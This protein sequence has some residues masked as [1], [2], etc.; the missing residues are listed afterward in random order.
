MDDVVDG[1]YLLFDRVSQSAV[2][3]CEVGL[4]LFV[5]QRWS[6]VDY[7]IAGAAGV[8]DTECD[9][10]RSDQQADWERVERSGD[11]RD[12]EVCLDAVMNFVR[13]LQMLELNIWLQGKKHYTDAI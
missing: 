9:D 13:M 12:G 1:A 8:E 7:R 3:V 5:V 11:E 6:A 4:D 10:G 2:G